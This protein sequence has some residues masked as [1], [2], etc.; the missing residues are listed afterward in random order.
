MADSTIGDLPI[1]RLPSLKSLQDDSLIPVEQNGKAMHMTG[2]QWAQYAKDVVRYDV[3]SAKMSAISA[4]TSAASAATYAASLNKSANEAKNSEENARNS[5]SS[6]NEAKEFVQNMTVS[7]KTLD[8]GQIT[9]AEKKYIPGGFHIEFG[10]PKGDKGD[11]GSTGPQ[12]PQGVQGPRG[13]QGIRGERGPQ[14]VQGPQGLKG[15]K[16]EKGDTGESGVVT[17]VSGMYALSVDADGNLWAYYDDSGDPPEFEYDAETGNL[18]Y[19]F[20]EV[21]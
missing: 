18:Y 7:S 16:G 15:D 14:G 2:A 17:P 4:E 12:G 1:G 9:Y 20:E 8:P 6:A 5:A 19:V 3:D 11:Q 21:S 10:I 13:E